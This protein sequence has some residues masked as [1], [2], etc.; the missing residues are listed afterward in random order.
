[1][2]NFRIF[3]RHKKK[4]SSHAGEEGGEERG[5]SFSSALGRRL[6]RKAS[7]PNLPILPPKDPSTPIPRAPSSAYPSIAT[8]TSSSSYSYSSIPPPSSSSI[9]PPSILAK[10]STSPT[11]VPSQEAW[12]AHLPRK[13]SSDSPSFRDPPGPSPTHPLTS[14]P[15]YD[16]LQYPPPSPSSTKPR[17]STSSSRSSR[18]HLPP[19]SISTTSHTTATTSTSSSPHSLSLS[20]SFALPDFSLDLGLGKEEENDL[21]G[22]LSARF[23]F[24]A[25]GNESSEVDPYFLSKD[26]SGPSLLSGSHGVDSGLGRLSSS[27]SSS[28]KSLSASKSTPDLRKAY[29]SLDTPLSPVPNHPPTESQGLPMEKG[30]E[31]EEEEEEEEEGKDTLPP[32]SLGAE[33]EEEEEEAKPTRAQLRE[34]ERAKKESEREEMERQEEEKKKVIER[35]LA[36]EANVSLKRMRDQYRESTLRH[37]MALSSS[38][39]SAP[40]MGYPTSAKPTSGVWSQGAWSS[41]GGVGSGA[42]IS[43]DPRRPWSSRPPYPPHSHQPQRPHPPHPPPPPVPMAVRKGSGAYGTGGM[44][45]FP[46]SLDETPLAQAYQPSRPL[47]QPPQAPHMVGGG[48][49]RGRRASPGIR[50]QA[51]LPDAVS[52]IR[53]QSSGP[54]ERRPSWRQGSAGN[55]PALPPLLTPSDAG[56]GPQTTS[57]PIVI[58]SPPPLNIIASTSSPTLSPTRHVAM[59]PA[60]PRSFTISSPPSQTPPLGGRRSPSPFH[61]QSSQINPMAH[62]PSPSSMRPI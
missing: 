57:L 23:S 47:P 51:G 54:P 40:G 19:L 33:E 12:E 16:F 34:A 29:T 55:S 27:S 20:P 3:G 21:L 24:L 56:M 17:S 36:R 58:S 43:V 14:G 18:E 4:D 59:N 35:K 10:S 39:P 44:G 11:N 26:L 52:R 53:S 9:P 30:Q 5:S 50:N 38:P 15:K 25:R 1:M 60:A 7:A 32:S 61:Y 2:S 31:R 41:Q 13:P 48:M 22:S 8:L 45:N 42:P 49:E 37:H 6:G 46:P 28:S 62:P